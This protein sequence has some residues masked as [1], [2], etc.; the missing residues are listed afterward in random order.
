MM[1]H[2]KIGAGGPEREAHAQTFCLLIVE[3]RKDEKPVE[4]NV[5]EELSEKLLI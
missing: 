2:E 4:Y 1:T 5:L 3:A